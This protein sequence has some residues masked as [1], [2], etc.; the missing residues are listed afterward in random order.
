MST[1][2]LL[3]FAAAALLLLVIPGPAVMY[4]VTRS[5]AQGRKAGLVSVAGIHL[6]TVVHIVAAMIG[7][8]AILAASATAFTVVKLVGA[9]Y[10]I[11]LG[12][13]S[14]RSYQRGKV[15]TDVSVAPR[16]LRRVFVDAVVLNVLNP[17]TAI[18]FLSFVPQF[19]DPETAHPVL[20]I[21]T[22]G[23]VFIVLG[24]VSDGA[25]ALAGGWV[26]GR[27]RRSPRLQ[28]RKDLVAGGTYLGLGAFTALAGGHSS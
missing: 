25:Y 11:W 1:T 7:L 23:A 22:L 14:I 26:G 4:I 20:D 19:I 3:A 13:Q 5:A 10:L 24:L 8:S 15:E 27:L 18:F 9:A 2:T 16:R 28:R 21:A 17:K 6:G 12:L